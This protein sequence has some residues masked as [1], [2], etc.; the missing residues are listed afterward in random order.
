VNMSNI[1]DWFK[2]Q[3]VWVRGTNTVLLALFV[4]GLGLDLTKSGPEFR[5]IAW[6]FRHGN[7]I[8]VNGVTF[9]V[10]YWY[11]PIDRR[12]EFA[13]H[14]IPGPL[15]PENDI[16]AGFSIDGRRIENDTKTWEESAER[17]NHKTGVRPDSY[18]LK[19]VSENLKCLETRDTHL[20]GPT[21]SC[22]G[23]GPIYRIFFIGDDNA[24]A[25]FKRTL[26]AAH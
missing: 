15:R 17:E 22:Y 19:I 21:L 24:L 7:S 1:R 5:A 6:H 11:A 14:D 8:N 12:D 26:A 16:Y 25:R 3:P 9:P 13:V 2:G 18:Q 4:L 20:P 23:D 10:Y